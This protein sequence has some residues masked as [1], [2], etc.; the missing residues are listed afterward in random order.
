MVTEAVFRTEDVAPGDRFDWWRERMSQSHAPVDLSSDHAADFWGHQRI[1]GLGDVT[2]W[3]ATFKPVVLSRTPKRVR[4]S[5]P[6]TYHLCLV[7][8]GRLEGT[9]DDREATF[10]PL[11]FSPNNSS[12][13][14]EVRA[15]GGPVTTIGVEIPQCLVPLPRAKVGEVM[16]NGLPAL[17]GREGIG[18]L[19]A[20]FLTRLTADTDSYRTSDGPRLGTVAVDLVSALFAHALDAEDLLTPETR[21]QTLVLRV[22]AFIRQHLQDPDLTPRA[23]AVA[24]H[25]SPS[26]LHSLFRDEDDT[27]AGYLRRQRLERAHHDLADPALRDMP[28]HRIASRWGFTHHAAF[29]RAFRAAY[30]SPPSR[31]RRQEP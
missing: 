15:K 27:V 20:Q 25:I 28:V 9:W 17:S 7:V 18:A 2:V 10:D 14:C 16:R 29:S 12:R 31:H 6:E 23:I 21:R 11:H 13:P 19:L 4:E 5:D 8:R 22:R 24:H 3:P 30:G 1:I 26:H